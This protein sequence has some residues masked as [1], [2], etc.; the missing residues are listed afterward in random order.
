M[1]CVSLLL[2]L[3]MSLTT[4]TTT[5]AWIALALQRVSTAIVFLHAHYA[6]LDT[7]LD[8]AS[9][10]AWAE[11]FE[12]ALVS[13]SCTLAGL[14]WIPTYLPLGFASGGERSLSGAPPQS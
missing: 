14:H 10:H 5:A 8:R 9:T 7:V 11:P 6:T 13:T 1:T 4:C 3:T 2:F 12:G